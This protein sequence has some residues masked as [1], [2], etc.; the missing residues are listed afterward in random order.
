M[1]NHPF[2]I[3]PRTIH[4]SKINIKHKDKNDK[5]K[6]TGQKTYLQYKITLPQSFIDAHKLAKVRRV[7]LIT[8]E[9]GVFLPNEETLMKAILLVPELSKLVQEKDNTL[10]PD[11]IKIVLQRFPEIKE[12][13]KVTSE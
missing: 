9:I 1:Q 7:Y 4:V 11:Q 12:Y 5:R 6:V 8:G 10:S 13:V 2:N 3:I